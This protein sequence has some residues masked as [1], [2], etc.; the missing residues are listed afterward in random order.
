MK[1]KKGDYKFVILLG[2]VGYFFAV[3]AQLLGTHYVGASLA[4]LLNSLNPM[5]MYVFAVFLTQEKFSLQKILSIVICAIGV[6]LIVGKGKELHR[7]GILLSVI[8][9]IVWS[10]VSI[11]MKKVM[12][13][14][15][16]L[17]IT[18]YGVGVAC[19]CYLPISIGEYKITGGF[20][21]DMNIVLLIIYMGA[22]CTGLGYFLWN[23]SLAV[24][25]PSTCA[26]FYPL[27]PVVSTILSV[28][29]LQEKISWSF[30]VGSLCIIVGVFIN[31]Y[32][33]RGKQTCSNS[34]NLMKL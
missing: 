14:Y 17:H 25:D 6:L 8:S 28:I 23:K 18:C 16:P 12:T 3:G 9:V 26:I 32:K 19:I 2:F 30:I 24:L 10:L 5:T 13:K 27:Q 33:T 29:I 11:L 34:K 31:L 22:I 20:P 15:P 7:V 4:S 21:L 1:L